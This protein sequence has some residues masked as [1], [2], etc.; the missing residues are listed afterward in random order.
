MTTA[1][2]PSSHTLAPLRLAF[3][4]GLGVVAWLLSAFLPYREAWRV[5]PWEL[6]VLIGWLVFAA[7]Y[8]IMSWR[9]IYKVDGDWIRGLV[10]QE[11][12]GR[13]ASG[14]IAI[15][16]SLVSLAG[17]MFALSRASGLKDQALLEGLL[18]GAALLSVALS[19]LLI[20]TIYTFRYAHL[21]YETP[22][23]GVKFPGTPEPDYLDFA[24]LA[25]TIGMTYQVSDTDL[26]QRPMR[27]LLTGHAL[28]SYVYGVV[29]IALAIS[30]VSSLLS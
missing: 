28:I 20:Q 1:P 26:D 11:D 23:G 8:L 21:Y 5:F 3:A 6:R 27:R 30:A 19:W 12:N 13:R 14:V 7:A 16:T 9:L 24:Y 29:I 18:I 22:E 2:L 17:V 15:L 25:F 10:R 4:F